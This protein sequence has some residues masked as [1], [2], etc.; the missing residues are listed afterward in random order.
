MKKLVSTLMIFCST[1]ALFAQTVPANDKALIDKF[2]TSMSFNK[3]ETLTPDALG[4]VF[5]GNFYLVNPG[6]NLASGSMTCSDFHFNAYNNKL[7]QLEELSEDKTLPVLLSMVKKEFVLKD[8]NAATAFETAINAIYPFEKSDTEQIKHLKK[9][10]KWIFIRG[11]FFD[12]LKAMIV[13]TN[14]TGKI[15]AIEFKLNYK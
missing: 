4:K 3:I 5:N 2:I 7:T 6:F 8:E 15:T 14:N 11:K 12:D 13:S 10:D 1:L 9:N